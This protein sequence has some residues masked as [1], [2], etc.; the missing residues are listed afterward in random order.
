[1]QS[2]KSVAHQVS[3]KGPLDTPFIR[4][5]KDALMRGAPA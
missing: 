5:I 4:V 2:R 1:M 3:L